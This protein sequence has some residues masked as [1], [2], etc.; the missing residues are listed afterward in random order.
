MHS[1]CLFKVLKQKTKYSPHFPCELHDYVCKKVFAYHTTPEDSL[2]LS[3]SPI[4]PLSLCRG[5]TESGCKTNPSCPY[6]TIE[7]IMST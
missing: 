2:S 3:R 6:Y 4:L 5:P 1:C 7:D